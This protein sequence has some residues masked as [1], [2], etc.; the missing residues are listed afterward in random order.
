MP[1][2]D[3]DAS[4]PAGVLYD[5]YTLTLD[6]LVTRAYDRLSQISTLLIVLLVVEVRGKQCCT[7]RAWQS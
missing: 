7:S 4:C 1:T 3:A 5:Q 6:R 2:H